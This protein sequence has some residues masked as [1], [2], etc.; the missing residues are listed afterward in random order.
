MKLWIML[1]L[2]YANIYADIDICVIKG[3][4]YRQDLAKKYHTK[5]E[6]PKAEVKNTG[7]R[8]FLVVVMVMMM[9]VMMMMLVMER[10]P[11]VTI[12]VYT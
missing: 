10:T 11:V 9:T 4:P 2:T 7:S 1:C 8:L 12:L 5:K 3:F 6:E